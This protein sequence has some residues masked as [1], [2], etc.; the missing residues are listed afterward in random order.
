LLNVIFVSG[1]LV[2]PLVYF[3]ATEWLAVFAFRIEMDIWMFVVPMLLVLII[4]ILAV[5]TQSI[6][7]AYL[8]PAKALRSE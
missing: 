1:L 5:L 6:K 3:L 4:A 7:V 2:L 8:N